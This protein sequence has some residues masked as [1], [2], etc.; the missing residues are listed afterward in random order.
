MQE[1]K[2]N[3]IK[4]EEKVLQEEVETLEEEVSNENTKIKDNRF[5]AVSIIVA[6]VLIAAAIV[7][8]VLYKSSNGGANGGQAQQNATSTADVMKIQSSDAVL[9]DVN[10]PVTII[11]Y[12]D[13][14]CPYCNM[15]AVETQPLI[16]KNYVDSGKVKMIFRDFIVNDRTASD[17]ESLDSALAAACANEQGKFWDFHDALSQLEYN[18]EVKNPQTAENNGN[19]NRDAFMSIAQKVGMDQTKFASCYDSQKYLKQVE[20][21]SASAMSMG[22]N[23]TPTFFVNGQQV[24]GA[25]PYSQFSAGIDSLLNQK[26]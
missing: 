1:N 7:F 22:L 25:L 11:E 24:V 13:Y 6:A 12:G 10:A 5:V 19:L 20:S 9:G 17:T 16:V 26:K 3:S 15:F 14:Q 8:A 23:A 18:D 2:N 4:E 21:V